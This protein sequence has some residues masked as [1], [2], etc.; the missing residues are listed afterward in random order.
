VAGISEDEARSVLQ[1]A[2]WANDS[3][4]A[5]HAIAGIICVLKN[6]KPNEAIWSYMN[7]IVHVSQECEAT[8][9]RDR[10]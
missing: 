1:L 6:G 2:P 8:H 4:R 10:I 9:F 7:V 3:L 5:G